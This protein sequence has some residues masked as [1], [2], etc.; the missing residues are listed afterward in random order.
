MKKHLL[1]F[2]FLLTTK[3]LTAQQLDYLNLPDTIWVAVAVQSAEVRPEFEESLKISAQ[4]YFYKINGRVKNKIKFMIAAD[5][6]FAD[7]HMHILDCRLATQADK[8]SSL[9]LTVVGIGGPLALAAGGI[10]VPVAF[11]FT[12][13]NR[14]VTSISYS[15]TLISLGFTDEHELL[16]KVSTGYF[17]TDRRNE[18]KVAKD[19]GYWLEAKGKKL[20]R[21]HR[22]AL[23]KVNRQL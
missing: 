2:A 11:Y 1:L 8:T 19:F 16:R 12:P 14:Y 18:G 21:K 13:S 15:G 22:K 4:Q 6:A 10:P 7:M 9:L 20:N 17:S 5:P 23:R 3:L